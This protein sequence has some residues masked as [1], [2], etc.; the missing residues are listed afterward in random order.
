MHSLHDLIRRWL[1]WGVAVL[2]LLA[3]TAVV[4]GMLLPATHVV[5]RQLTLSRSPEAAWRAIT[6]SALVLAW[7][8]DLASLERLPDSAG[9]AR[10]RERGAD[11]SERLVVVLEEAAPVYRVVSM[12]DQATG[13]VSRWEMVIERDP[14]GIRLTVTEHGT[15]RRRWQRFVSQFTSGHA[16][17][18]ERWMGQLAEYFE[19]PP[20]IS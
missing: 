3:T 11:G 18:M 10:W 13:T 1:G 15:I 5:S 16:G 14:A 7:R 20:R 8:T 6:D 2:T 12:D 9:R 17:P 19:E 4:A